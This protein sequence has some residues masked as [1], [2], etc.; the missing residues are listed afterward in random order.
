MSETSFVLILIEAHNLKEWLIDLVKYI[1][2]NE[3]IMLGYAMRFGG[4]GS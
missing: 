4:D 3:Y 2:L 1:L